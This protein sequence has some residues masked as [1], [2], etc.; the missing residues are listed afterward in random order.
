[1]KFL[2][3]LTIAISIVVSGC[4]GY[5]FGYYYGYSRGCSFVVTNIK[6]GTIKIR[7]LIKDEKKFPLEIF[8]ESDKH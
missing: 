1:M 8:R 7:D 6:N 3:A 5:A 4:T 2:A